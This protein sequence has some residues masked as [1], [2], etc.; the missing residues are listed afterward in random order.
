VQRQPGANTVE[1]ADRIRAM[2]PQIEA[3]LPDGVRLQVHFDRSRF[4]R[5]RCTRSTSP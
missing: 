4:V 5:I 2:L 1:V 3:E